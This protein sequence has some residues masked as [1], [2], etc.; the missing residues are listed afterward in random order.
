MVEKQKREGKEKT[1][2]V[3]LGGFD[4]DTIEEV[5]DMG[6]EEKATYLGRNTKTVLNLLQNIDYPN[7]LKYELDI[8]KQSVLYHI[9]KLYY[10]D[11]IHLY[12][13]REGRKYWKIT[14]EGEAVLNVVN[15][16]E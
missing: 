10:L 8:S 1:E 9:G 3:F 4:P 5:G 14:D 6:I 2:D 16:P 13:Q 15:T 12:N 7:S 11:L